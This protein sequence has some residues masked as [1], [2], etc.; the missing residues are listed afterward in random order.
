MLGYETYFDSAGQA[1]MTQGILLSCATHWE[2]ENLLKQMTQA[3]DAIRP[4]PH[5][6]H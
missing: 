2:N 4:S 3:L 6:T 5:L 1:S